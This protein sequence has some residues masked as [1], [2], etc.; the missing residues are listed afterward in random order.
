MHGIQF[1]TDPT[2]DH[3]L[4]SVCVCEPSEHVINRCKT[5]LVPVS[6]SLKCNYICRGTGADLPIQSNEAMAFQWMSGLINHLYLHFFTIYGMRLSQEQPSRSFSHAFFR[7]F[8]ILARFCNFSFS[9]RFRTSMRFLVKHP[10]QSFQVT[11]LFFARKMHSTSQF[12]MTI[13]S[14]CV[15]RVGSTR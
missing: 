7:R 1:P 9:S 4:S 2:M 15:T 12:A 10:V 8:S 11:E 3:F 14:K 5:S 6:L 13:L